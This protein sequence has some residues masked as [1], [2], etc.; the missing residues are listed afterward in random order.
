MKGGN[1][2]KKVYSHIRDA[3]K[4]SEEYAKWIFF[5]FIFASHLRFANNDVEPMNINSTRFL[6]NTVYLDC[7]NDAALEGRFTATL[8]S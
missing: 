3:R 4:I 7:F 2:R 8:K 5:A 6:S 1:N